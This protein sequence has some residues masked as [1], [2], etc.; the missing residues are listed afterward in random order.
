MS[1]NRRDTLLEDLLEALDFSEAQDAPR[2]LSTSAVLTCSRRCAGRHHVLQVEVDSGAWHL[3]RHEADNS[4]W[5]VTQTSGGGGLEEALAHE[6]GLLVLSS[7]SITHWVTDDAKLPTRTLLARLTVEVAEVASEREDEPEYCAPWSDEDEDIVG[8]FGEAN[9]LSVWARINGE[10]VAVFT[11]GA[12]VVVPMLVDLEDGQL[13]PVEHISTISWFSESGGAPISWNGGN[14]LS[15]LYGPFGCARQWGDEGTEMVVLE[16]PSSAVE[17]APVVAD[18]IIARESAALA[19]ITFEPLDAAGT[20]SED[21]RTQWESLLAAP[22]VEVTVEL[23]NEAFDSMR[24]CLGRDPLYRATKEALQDPGG[25]LGQALRTA[26][27]ELEESGVLGPLMSGEWSEP[28]VADPVA[29]PPI[30]HLLTDGRRVLQV[31][32]STV[33]PADPLRES[34]L[35][36]WLDKGFGVAVYGMWPP[37]EHSLLLS[38]GGPGAYLP[39]VDPPA[40][41]P[42][43]LSNGGKPPLCGVIP[44]NARRDSASDLGGVNGRDKSGDPA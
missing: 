1:A 23:P 39:T 20:L 34:A 32:A 4:E 37:S 42:G 40:N 12:E 14:S 27:E 35:R 16:L 26:L 15:R 3:T 8:W 6:P 17:L 22:E 5:Q 10:R 2:G 33:M 29:A 13:E 36:R 11:D 18:W 31:D 7:N 44:S 9:W 43:Y 24:S 21:E 25:D 28:P 19:A 41:A 30:E 38:Y